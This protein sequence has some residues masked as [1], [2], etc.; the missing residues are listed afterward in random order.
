VLNL[1]LA[2]SREMVKV[3][4]NWR[5][6]GYNA[7]ELECVP[8]VLLR[9]LLPVVLFRSAVVVAGGKNNTVAGS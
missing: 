8:K 6:L 9:K 3:V 5:V 1:I 7:D 4:P 2:A